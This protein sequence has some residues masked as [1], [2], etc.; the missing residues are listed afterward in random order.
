M[1]APLYNFP[2]SSKFGN[3]GTKIAAVAKTT[4]NTKGTASL[5]PIFF[6]KA[7]FSCVSNKYLTNLTEKL[8]KT[9]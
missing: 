5:I 1:S 2:P 8:K 3:E 4:N 9:Y 7:F 6:I